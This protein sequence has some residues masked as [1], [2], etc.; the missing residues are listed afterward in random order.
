MTAAGFVLPVGHYLGRHHPQPNAPVRYHKV[1][2][3]RDLL[4][5]SDDVFRLWTLSH[6]VPDR[7]GS[8]PWTR[9]AV[10]D[11]A[12]QLPDPERGLD[13][14]IGDGLVVE[15]TPGTPDA[16]RFARDYRVQ[17]LMTGLGNTARDPLRFGIG[18]LGQPPAVT[19]DVLG[20]EL[21]QWGRLDHDLW[22][23][24]HRL[25]S[26]RGRVTDGS[27]DPERMLTEILRRLP[28]LLG[29]NAVYLDRSGNSHP[30]SARSET[31]R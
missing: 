8:R 24:A 10:L 14:L 18:V 29:H 22:Q 27:A 28:V 13:T 21:W 1:R 4:R 19:V 23:V 5:L 16:V 2:L 12:R 17:P 3:G 30:R 7:P 6:G 31:S 26:V 25:A 20:F 9:E 11:A 15:I